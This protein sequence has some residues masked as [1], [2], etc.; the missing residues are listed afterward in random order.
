[1]SEF[2]LT[3]KYRINQS[4]EMALLKKFI[5]PLAK[6]GA[7]P[8]LRLVITVSNAYNFLKRLFSAR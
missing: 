4:L 1:M 8:R 5:D 7:L 2:A 3:F 6:N